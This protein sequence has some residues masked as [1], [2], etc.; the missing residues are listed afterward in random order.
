MSNM[1]LNRH[2][3]RAIR[4]IRGLTV[5]ELAA[6]AAITQPYL[7]NIEA[8]RKVPSGDVIHQLAGALGVNVEALVYIRTSAAV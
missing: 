7:S 1:F 6:M 2:T 3:L 8:G 5:T 4:E